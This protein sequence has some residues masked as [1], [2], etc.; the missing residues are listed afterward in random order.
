[1][2][3]TWDSIGDMVRECGAIPT[4]HTYMSDTDRWFGHTSKLSIS[5]KLLNG[6]TDL[7]KKA[8]K[9]LSKIDKLD[10]PLVAQF[11]SVRSPF[12]GRVNFGEWMAGS[13][14]PMRRKVRRASELGPLKIFVGITSSAAIDSNKLEA[15]GIAIL[16][17]LQKIQMVRPVELYVF[18]ETHG[19]SDGAVFTVV[20]VDSKPLEVAT[21][22]V[23]LAHCA[24]ARHLLYDWSEVNDGFNGMWPNGYQSVKYYEKRKREMEVGND[25][26]IFE[27]LTSWD[28][29]FDN[30]EKWIKTQLQKLGLLET[31]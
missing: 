10:L 3:K 21:A 28:A 26:L 5:N 15:R 16:A 9:V 1:M 18:C 24:T 8:D 14:T 11:E 31:E 30:P 23:A 4:M 22:S 17:L 12:G 7:A 29:N 25:D 2:V 27:S 19:N 6:D 20:K 13:P